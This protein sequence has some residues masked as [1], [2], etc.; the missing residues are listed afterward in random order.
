MAITF[1]AARTPAASTVARI[2]A[3]PAPA[4][5]ANDGIAADSGL[6]GSD[7]DRV[8]AALRLFAKHGLGA[9]S[10]ARARADAA[11]AAGDPDGQAEWLGLLAVLDPAAARRRAG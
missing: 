1:A 5:P 11:A 10:E 6:F 4:R 2:L 3:C 8:R 7:G 9:A